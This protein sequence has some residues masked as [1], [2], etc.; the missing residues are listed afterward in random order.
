[1]TS[2]WDKLKGDLFVVGTGASAKFNASVKGQFTRDDLN[3]DYIEGYRHAA[4]LLF[5][6]VSNT[7]KDQDRLIF[8][9]VTLWRQCIE[10]QLKELIALISQIEGGDYVHPTDTH[11]LLKLW[12]KLRP[13]LKGLGPVEPLDD[14]Q[15]HLTEF[16]RVDR[17][18]FGFRFPYEKDLATLSMAN[19]P[20]IINMLA[21]LTLMNETA[22][23]LDG[24]RGFMR[25]HLSDLLSEQR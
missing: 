10:L 8:P 19:A 7:G 6:H 16:C 5:E 25:S 15:R 22:E 3:T 20:T 18:S 17:F 4:E 1:M 9:F 11:D 23:L 13:K 24:V 2:A 14:I 21:F 12:M